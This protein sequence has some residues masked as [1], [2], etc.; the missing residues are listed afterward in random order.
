M[1][2]KKIKEYRADYYYR[3]GNARTRSQI[4]G[5]VWQHLEGATTESA[6]IAYLRRRHPGYEIDLMS[7]EWR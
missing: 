1:T 6:V 5:N 3:K 2:D 7:V 4:S